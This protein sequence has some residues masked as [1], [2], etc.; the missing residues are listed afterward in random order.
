MFQKKSLTV[1]IAVFLLFISFWLPIELIKKQL[2]QIRKNENLWQNAL[3]KEKILQESAS[4][5]ADLRPER[6]IEKSV[7]S[8][9]KLYLA[10]RKTAELEN[11]DQHF[12][13]FLDDCL[14]R[15]FGIAPLF[16]V[17]AEKDP[18]RQA[19][20]IA[21]KMSLKFPEHS[22]FADFLTKMGLYDLSHYESIDSEEP[23][24]HYAQNWNDVTGI[25]ETNER[26]RYLEKS[27]RKYF[28]PFYSGVN[29]PN[30]VVKYIFDR[31]NFQFIY[32][33][34]VTLIR[35]QK[36]YGCFTVGILEEDIDLGKMLEMAQNAGNFGQKAFARHIVIDKEF[37]GAGFK[38]S[39]D[40][41]F[42]YDS[43]PFEFRYLLKSKRRLLKKT[44]PS[45]F[46]IS[47]IEVVSDSSLAKNEKGWINYLPTFSQ[48]L[49]GLVFFAFW[50]K[51]LL[52][53][54]CIRARLRHKFALL[55]ILAFSSPFLTVTVFTN[56]IDRRSATSQ[57]ELARSRLFNGLDRLESIIRESKDRQTLN[58]LGI[59]KVITDY[60]QNKSLPNFPIRE[61]IRLFKNN[62]DNSLFFDSQGHH[63]SFDMA[64]MPKHP[65]TL[66][67]SNCAR[68]L[69][70][71][72]VLDK[73]IP[74]VKKMLKR[75][76]FTDGLMEG[77][78]SLLEENE[79]MAKESL[80]TP[81]LV[82]TTTIS[83]S[84][85]FLIPDLSTWP[86]RPM[87]IVI[88]GQ[89]IKNSVLTLIENYQNF[90]K[91][92]LFETNSAYDLSLAIGQRNSSDFDT[93][94]YV[95][96]QRLAD[97]FRKI[98]I[99]VAKKA[100]S[101]SSFAEDKNGV[102]LTAWRYFQDTPIVLAG[103]CMV[104][105]GPE[106]GFGIEI[107]LAGLAGFTAM[108]LL[109]LSEI[110]SNLFLPP[111]K[112]LEIAAKSVS[113]FDDLGARVAIENNDEFDHMGQ[114][115]NQMTTGLLQRRHLSRFVSDRLVANI[116]QADKAEEEAG[117]EAEVTILCS[118]IRDFTTI[119][120]QFPPAEI[121]QVLNE[122]FTE[123]EKAIVNFGGV[124]DKFVG[125]AIVAVFYAD[126]C[127]NAA[128]SACMAA[129]EMRKALA[130]FNE[131]RKR[132]GRFSI[133]NGIGLATGR[134]VTGRIGQPGQRMEYTIT[135]VLV[136][137]AND[138]EA[139]SKL[140]TTTKITMDEQT[141]NL[142]D[143]LFESEPVLETETRVFE[144]IRQ[145]GLRS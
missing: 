24:L 82:K 16:V 33:C 89:K 133:E 111:I 121:V 91:E 97:H 129:V 54:F 61:K 68:F 125:D 65:D 8:S 9:Q 86:L 6:F 52:F 1:T 114:A 71:L 49:L 7:A 140:A 21:E 130:E 29:A 93:L 12:I 18:V 50:V 74:E 72:G 136:K 144:L 104:Y 44:D 119:S 108:I 39:G 83:R 13:E 55:L 56:L 4:F 142:V 76:E 37:R 80:N 138:V 22:E 58:N 36:Y 141:R 103:H 112:A 85:Y 87:A 30:R 35:N 40:K 78:F 46:A 43:V 134:V 32:L 3:L 124:I 42:F 10:N 128:K 73:D 90:R 132:N 127:V 28:G 5:Q 14:R 45:L 19:S 101:G 63:L 126:H 69:D 123:M 31:F 62:V 11:P 110:M 70:R 143:D 122:Y 34:N 15:K 60:L 92:Y 107:V 118:D 51:S 17:A 27:F 75:F 20:L 139:A 77:F 145:R 117:E 131:L 98:F 41:L 135:G 66:E 105:N 102:V 96:N 79:I 120:E 53:G 99:Q 95:G 84:Q 106:I 64:A 2:N 23:V 116:A 59:K 47:G 88:L 26:A 109:I 48:K 57:I 115:F 81:R 100:S 67:L 25:A 113:D 38:R 94:L 137:K